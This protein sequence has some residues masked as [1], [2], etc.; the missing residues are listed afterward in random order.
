MPVKRWGFHTTLPSMQ[1]VKRGIDTP[2]TPVRDT[3][4][5]LT[6]MREAYLREAAE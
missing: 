4:S 2:C 6:R 5:E 3:R 1:F